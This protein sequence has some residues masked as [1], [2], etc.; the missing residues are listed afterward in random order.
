MSSSLFSKKY[1]KSSLKTKSNLSD[2]SWF[3]VS[4]FDINQSTSNNNNSTTKSKLKKLFLPKT[5]SIEK[6]EFPLH[7]SVSCKNI[8]LISSN[9]N[10]INQVH[11]LSVININIEDSFTNARYYSMYLY[12]KDFVFF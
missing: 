10:S 6:N 7:K 12:T 3:S 11:R 2:S 9:L 4:T 5:T 1:K 8:A